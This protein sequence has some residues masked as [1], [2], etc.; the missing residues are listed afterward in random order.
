VFDFH[1]SQRARATAWPAGAGP[2]PKARSGRR[3]RLT[4]ALISTVGLAAAAL[5][6]PIGTAKA[7]TLCNAYDSITMGKYWLNNNVWGSDTGSGTQCI[8]D[9]STNG[10]TIAWNTTWDWT[11]QSNSVKSYDSA[12]LGWHWGTKIT[13]TGLPV[14]ISANRPVNSRW[15]YT[16]S[17]SGTLNVSYDLWLHE[18]SNPT[19]ENNP[20]DEVMIWLTTQGGAGPVGTKQATVTIDGASWDLYRGNIGWNV[21]SFVRTANNN[22][23]TLNLSNF[24]NDLVSRGWVP[25]SK[26]LTSVQ[27]GTE[28]FIGAGSLRTTAYSTTVG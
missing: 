11:G 28:V 25:S 20:T 7:A 26:Y 24:L 12:V 4:I 23:S 8:E 27:A 10:D 18:I 3:R 2:S 9:V 17:A 6:G 5:I 14:Q 13:N 19:W 22:N 1:T 21:F 16:A 15:Q